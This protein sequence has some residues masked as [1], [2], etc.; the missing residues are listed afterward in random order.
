MAVAAN[1]TADAVWARSGPPV[2][3]LEVNLAHA[4]PTA[5]AA[6]LRTLSRAAM[7]SYLRYWREVV[8]L[9]RW[10]PQQVQ[11]TVVPHDVA[12]V[13][14]ALAS[15]RGVVAAL[16][17]MGNWDLA[18]AWACLEGMPVATVAERL[19]PE[20]RFAEFVR[21]RERLGM[22]VLPLTGGSPVTPVLQRVLRAGGFVCLLADRALDGRGV[23]VPFLGATARL[24]LGP[25]WLAQTTGARLVPVSTSYDGARMHLWVHE[26]VKV[27]AGQRGIVAATAAVAGVLGA[28]IRRDPADWHMLQPVFESQPGRA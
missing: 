2:R 10:S 14:D 9:P 25:A 13:R 7:R 15:G 6:A 24:P 17:H 18:G 1:A 26:P 22:T 28:A 16:P 3:R 19:R 23:R 5:D 27:A 21:Y 4:V 20:R 8:S 11:A 12:R